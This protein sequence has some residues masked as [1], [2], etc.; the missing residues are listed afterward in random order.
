MRYITF[1]MSI[2]LFFGCTDLSDIAPKFQDELDSKEQLSALIDYNKMQ[3]E[4]QGIS[5][6]GLK[7]K[8][9]RQL[10]DNQDLRDNMVPYMSNDDKNIRLIHLD[11]L[12]ILDNER[13]SVIIKA[14]EDVTCK[15][16][17][18]DIFEL[19]WMVNGQ[20]YSSLAFLDKRT[21]E[22]YYDNILFNVGFSSSIG[23]STLHSLLSLAEDQTYI[24]SSQDAVEFFVDGSRKAVASI[25]WG[26]VGHWNEEIRTIGDEQYKYYTYSHESVTYNNTSWSA[27]GYDTYVDMVELGIATRS[28]YL[29][30]YALWAGPIGTFNHQT[31]GNLLLQPDYDF[32]DGVHS[33]NGKIQTVGGGP[34]REPELINN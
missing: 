13:Y 33:G 29:F 26:I 21:Y 23:T 22:L 12:S 25:S 10:N 11:S 15:E 30:K 1:I 5:F 2:F 9:G 20:N 14:I 7:K 6:L 32:C 17:N 27:Q 8:D 24:E 16:E 18:Y 3:L 28:Y 34:T 19:S 31:Y 4:H